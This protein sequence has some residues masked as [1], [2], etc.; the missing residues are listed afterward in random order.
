M[1][2]SIVNDIFDDSIWNQIMNN[3]KK[4]HSTIYIDGEQNEHSRLY[5]NFTQGGGSHGYQDITG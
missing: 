4:I 2:D 3:S 5:Y 1:E